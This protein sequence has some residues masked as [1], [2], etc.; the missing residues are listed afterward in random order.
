MSAADIHRQITEV[1]GTEAMND[2]KVRKWARKFKDGRTNIHD[3]ERLGHPSV[4]TDVLMQAVETKIRENRI[5]TITILSLEFP[6]VSQSVV[7]KIVTEDLNFKKFCSR[8]VPR[9]LIAEHKEKRIAISFDFLIR[10]KEEGVDSLSRIVTGD[11]TSV[12]HTNPDSKQ[13]SIK[14]LYTYAPSRQGQSKTNA[15]KAQDYGNS[16]LGRCF[17]GGGWEVLD[18]APYSPEF[19]PSDFRLIRYLKHS[20]GG[21]HFSDNEEVKAIVNSWLSDQAADFFEEGFKT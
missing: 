16:V 21:K 9:L 13:Q 14:W 5:F 15:V 10:Y 18:V 1:Y 6:D 4:I 7:Y 19:A 12:F 2:S 17:A 3:E 11:E 8:W 20:F